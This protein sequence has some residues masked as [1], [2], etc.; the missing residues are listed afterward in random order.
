ME[1]LRLYCWWSPLP[2]TLEKIV[3]DLH[4]QG[5]L[6]RC[7]CELH[8]NFDKKP[9]DT[10][11]LKFIKTKSYGEEIYDEYGNL[12]D[13][14]ALDE[15]II[16]AMLPYESMAIRMGCRRNN[17]PI[18]E[19]EREKQRYMRALRYWNYVLESERI[20]ACFFC[21]GPHFQGAYIVYAL[22]QIKGI[23]CKMLVNTVLGTMKTYGG[24]IEDLGKNIESYYQNLVNDDI[25]VELED[26]ETAGFY[27]RQLSE[28]TGTKEEANKRR[29]AENKYEVK[30]KRKVYFGNYF[31]IKSFLKQKGMKV[32]NFVAAIF[33][34]HNIEHYRKNRK[35]YTEIRENRVW[36]K[37]FKK[38]YM[39]TQDQYNKM[40]EQ[41]DLSQKYVF[42]AL[43]F[44]P[45]MTTM[46]LAG[47]FVDQ[48]T[49]IW[50]LAKCA[51]K[52]GLLV[53][54]KE[55]GHLPFRDKGFYEMISGIKTTE[56]THEIMQNCVATAT[57]TGTCILESVVKGKPVL[58]FGNGYSW[59]GIPGLFKVDSEKAGENALGEILKP[60]YKIDETRVKKYF[61]AIQ[62]NT[63]RF[64]GSKADTD[65]KLQ[66][67]I[68]NIKK[69][70][71]CW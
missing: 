10:D 48:Y 24:S 11:T 62:K 38:Y 26:D 6:E 56:S 55:H 60:D 17:I 4:E 16:K 47:E 44:V 9:K 43:Q 63:L 50:L 12:D 58:V 1:K 7:V 20:N 68:E 39:M 42:F 36:A 53:Y 69:C 41:A 70:V 18:I 15:E 23:P 33:K 35:R 32:K 34:Y 46:P 22:A 14:P 30:R 29:E 13:L 40:A 8:Q 45:E 59:K 71:R 3:N 31:G 67:D 2:S 51:E 61:Y 21:N 28:K 25:E 64:Y 66:E 5:V 54:V 57:Q 52:Y 49:S 19:Y 37:W 65:E 27:N